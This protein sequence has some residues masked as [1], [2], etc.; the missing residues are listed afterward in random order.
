MLPIPGYGHLRLF[1]KRRERKDKADHILSLRHLGLEEVLKLR[2]LDPDVGLLVGSI[3][4][5]TPLI[6]SRGDYTWYRTALRAE[7]VAGVALRVIPITERDS[8]LCT[9][10]AVVVGTWVDDDQ[11][12]ACQFSVGPCNFGCTPVRVPRPGKPCRGSRK[13]PSRLW[14]I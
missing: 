3:R 13:G 5:G 8:L 1:S 14:S 2:S 12:Y 10:G 7:R 4:Y 9:G 6:V 11:V